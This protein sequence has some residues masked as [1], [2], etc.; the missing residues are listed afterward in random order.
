MQYIT[1]DGFVEG[2]DTK[3]DKLLKLIYRSRLGRIIIKPMLNPSFSRVIGDL[4]DSRMSACLIK[5]FVKSAKIDLS[6]AQDHKYTS[7]NDFFTR[8]LEPGSR[9]VDTDANALV[10]PCD[11]LVSAFTIR[12]SLRVYV[13]HMPYKVRDLLKD[14]KLAEHYN[15]G[16]MLV[17]R[18]CVD[19][20]HRYIYPD[21]GYQGSI[22]NI[23]GRLHTV[24]PV[25]NDVY[26][27]YKE[28][29]RQYCI[30]KS[31]HFGKI[32][33]MEVGAL[34]VGKIVNEK[35]NTRVEKG[36]EKGYFAY[37]GSTVILLLEKNRAKINQNI[38]DNTNCGFETKVRQGERIAVTGVS[39]LINIYTD[40]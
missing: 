32:L 14:S 39:D 27:I 30:L 6:D 5:P 3:Q 4:L 36:E 13:K 2:H 40:S 35:E 21:S 33:L 15:G 34:M 28:N 26:P 17:F 29:S 23:K 25:A 10:S 24:N 31:D 18:L 7:F 12:N 19:D 22:R 38:I 37:G 11:S 20:Y 9:P 8:K 1:A 16:T